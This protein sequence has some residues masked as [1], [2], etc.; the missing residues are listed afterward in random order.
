MQNT[1]GAKAPDNDG[2]PPEDQ[3]DRDLATP[4]FVS[5][6]ARRESNALLQTVAA[7][8]PEDE[9]LIARCDRLHELAVEIDDRI[10]AKA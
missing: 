5:W 4:H 3:T 7:N 2:P 6:S 10:A 1:F 8:W 9:E